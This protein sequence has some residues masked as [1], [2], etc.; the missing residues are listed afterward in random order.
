MRNA[1]EAEDQGYSAAG[2]EMFLHRVIR[3]IMEVLFAISGISD[4]VVA[5][6]SLPY[7]KLVKK[8]FAKGAR[9]AAFHELHGAF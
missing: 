5:E 8:L 4:A 6:T 1:P 9:G 7:W 3:Q 2:G